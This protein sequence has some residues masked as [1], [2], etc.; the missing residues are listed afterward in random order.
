MR[1]FIIVLIFLG[2]CTGKGFNGPC[3]FIGPNGAYIPC[4]AAGLPAGN[5]ATN[6]PYQYQYPR[7]YQ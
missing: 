6:R 5:W 4:G 2:G 3:G 1:I 7:Y